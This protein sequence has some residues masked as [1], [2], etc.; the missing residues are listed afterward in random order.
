MKLP[1]S[2]YSHFNPKH[3]YTIFLELGIIS[4]LLIFIVATNI[5]IEPTKNNDLP[6]VAKQEVVKMED[7]IKTKQEEMPPA[8]PRP[9]VPVA[10]PNSSI[11]E[12]EIP[13]INAEFEFNEPLEIPDPPKQ[14]DVKQ[15]DE[16]D[17]FVA[18]EQMPELIGTLADLQRKINY[19]PLA[20]ASGIEG[21]VVVQFIINA[22]GEV[23]HPIVIRGIGGGC[24]EEAIRVTKLARFKPGRQRGKAV[25]V[26]YSLPFMFILR[27]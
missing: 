2:Q 7:V 18:V 22:N 26:R 27:D 23:E 10:V 4:S 15:E 11:I 16:E 8:P 14:I 13:D 9:Q 19:P 5:R 20:A 12:D 6:L 3:Y 24:D 17:F 21:R 1:K 25:R